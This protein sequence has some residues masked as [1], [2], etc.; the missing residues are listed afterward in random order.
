MILASNLLVGLCILFSFLVVASNAKPLVANG[1]SMPQKASVAENSKV[2]VAKVIK[3]RQNGPYQPQQQVPNN[4]PYQPQP[5]QYQQQPSQY[6]QQQPQQPFQPNQ[7]PQRQQQQQ[8]YPQQQPYQQQN[9]QNPNSAIT[10]Q[11][12]LQNGGQ[13][14]T[15]N[16]PARQIDD[17]LQPFDNAYKQLFLNQYP[18]QA[19]SGPQ[20][21]PSNHHS[22]Q[23]QNWW[24]VDPNFEGYPAK[25]PFDEPYQQNAQGPQPVYQENVQPPNPQFF[26]PTT[27]RVYTTMQPV[28]T[29]APF[30]NNF[31]GGGGYDPNYPNNNNQNNGWNNQ[32]QQQQWP[33]NPNNYNP[34]WNTNNNPNNPNQHEYNAGIFQQFYKST[35]TTDMPSITVNGV[36]DTYSKSFNPYEGMTERRRPVT[37]QVQWYS[38]YYDLTAPIAA[39]PFNNYKNI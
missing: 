15:D 30:N 6:Q 10:Q 24:N 12:P 14:T 4:R 20:I 19:D 29:T 17:A 8:P 21:L 34:N 37:P 13:L 35:T 23:S 16:K 18:L 36:P 7:Y 3:K 28:L 11:T 26:I 31:N 39:L 2:E 25:S 27:T 22:G 1:T 9:F 5:N 33:M 38:R 32:Q